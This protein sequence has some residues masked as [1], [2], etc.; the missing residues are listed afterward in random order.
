M[1]AECLGKSANETTVKPITLIALVEGCTV[2][3]RTD[4]TEI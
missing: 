1:E 2:Q 4:L 3:Y